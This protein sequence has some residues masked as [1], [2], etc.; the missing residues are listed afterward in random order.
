MDSL[1]RRFAFGPF[2]VDA[3]E[4]VLFRDGAPVPLAPKA[5]D[6]LLT[7]VERHGHVV[8]KEQLMVAVWPDTAVEENN[9]TQNISILRKTLGESRGDIRFIETVARRGYRFRGSAVRT[10]PPARS[11][12]ARVAWQTGAWSAA[13]AIGAW[14]GFAAHGSYPD[15]GSLSVSPLTSRS[16]EEGWP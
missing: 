1:N 16:G 6:T 11:T 14:I 15:T 10:A 9:L 8:S 13:V 5:F 7:L 2:V 3:A 12:V 4:R